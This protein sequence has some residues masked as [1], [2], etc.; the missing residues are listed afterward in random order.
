MQ[1]NPRERILKIGVGAVIALFLLDRAVLSPFMESWKHQGERIAELG[2][3]V[4][5]GEQLIEREK[6][7]RDRWAEI[8]KTDLGEDVSAGE[9]NVF[10]AIARWA[11]DSHISFTNLTPQWRKRD[12]GSEIFEC[13]AAATGDQASLAR[14][15]YEIETDALPGRVEEC[16][17]SA[18][19][20]KGKELALALRFSFVRLTAAGRETK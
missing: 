2:L 6:S 9:S 20:A 19:D 7:L 12:A 13:R 4:Q 5:R 15:L 17:F 10:K 16:E 18:R 11:R 1:N 3:K 8:Q 14:L